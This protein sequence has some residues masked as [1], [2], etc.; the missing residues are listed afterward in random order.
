MGKLQLEPCSIDVEDVLC[1]LSKVCTEEDLACLTL[2]VCVNVIYN[3]NANFTSETDNPHIS[4]VEFVSLIVVSWSLFTK[5]V[6]VKFCKVDF[7]Y[8]LLRTAFLASL[9]TLYDSVKAAKAAGDAKAQKKL[10]A[11]KV[12]ADKAIAKTDYEEVWEE[13]I[14]SLL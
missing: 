10:D 1:W 13:V 4:S 5:D 9:W 14:D 8:K 2:L 6:H 7:T 11:A 12:S 3:D